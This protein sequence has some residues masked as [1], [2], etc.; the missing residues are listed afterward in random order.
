M[1]V[2]SIPPA[3][4]LQ[5]AFLSILPR[6]ELHAHISFRYVRCPHHKQ[7]LVE[8]T[9]P[10]AWSWFFRLIERGNNPLTIQR[11]R[12]DPTLNQVFLPIAILFISRS[13]ALLSMARNPTSVQRANADQLFSA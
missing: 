5:S 9:R 13:E 3:D 4:T 12:G 7:D 1:S 6:I 11:P 8:E 2:K 10:L